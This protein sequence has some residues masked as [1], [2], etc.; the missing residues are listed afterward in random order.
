MFYAVSG[1][2]LLR[3]LTLLQQNDNKTCKKFVYLVI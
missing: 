1:A 3:L 2:I